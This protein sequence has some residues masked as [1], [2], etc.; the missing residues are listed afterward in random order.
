[1]AGQVQKSL[2]VLHTLLAAWGQVV[3][4]AL[5]LIVST[6][7]MD[8]FYVDFMSIEMTMEPNR[9][10]K[11]KNILVFQ[12]HFMK[13]V[14]VYMTLDQT[15]KTVDKF[16]YQGYISIFGPAA[17]VLS[18]HSVNFMSNIISKMCKLFGMKKLRTMPYH[19]QTNGLVERSHQTIVQ[20]I[21]KLGEDK[22][23]DWPGYLAEIVHAYNSTQSTMMGYSP[24]YLMFGHR[25]RLLVDFYFPILRSV[26]VPRRYLC[27]V[28]GWICSYC[29]R[30]LECH[31]PRGP[32]PVYGRSL[33]T[34]MAPWPENRY[35]R[36][37]AWWSCL[38]QGRCHSREQ[39]DHG[40]MEGQTPQCSVSDVPSY[41]MKDQQGNSCILHCNGLLLVMSEVGVPLHVGV[42]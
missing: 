27:Q 37:E 30:P 26:E 22:K 13:H 16:L 18:D 24:H 25:P 11:V 38:Y 4:G 29:S 32:S 14:M 6:T 39:E 35:H 8:L 17:R 20:M 34:E 21:R 9:L 41:K 5:H 36:F 12:D 2:E 28:C 40:Q 31:P 1:M 19:P 23:A 3:Q 42:C 7:T 15:T 33:K 10:P